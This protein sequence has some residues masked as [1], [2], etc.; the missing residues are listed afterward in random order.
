MARYI[1][2]PVVVAWLAGA[3]IAVLA[4]CT[5]PK[6]SKELAAESAYAGELLACVESAQTLEQSKAC[7]KDVNQRWGIVETVSDAG[8]E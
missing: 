4:N 6:S 2:A 3:A 1:V 5:P 8:G 7:R